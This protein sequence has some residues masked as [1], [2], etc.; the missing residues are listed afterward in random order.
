MEAMN[1]YCDQVLNQPRCSLQ[2]KLRVYDVKV[3]VLSNTGRVHEAINV[4][5]DALLGMGI[6]IPRNKLMRR[7]YLLKNISQYKKKADAW[8]VEDI[9]QL[10]VIDDPAKIQVMLL[11]DRLGT[12]A[13]IAGDMD[14]FSICS[15]KSVDHCLKDG[16]S[17]HS[18]ATPFLRL[19]VVFNALLSD[20]RGST[21]LGEKGVLL[22]EELKTR[23]GLSEVLVKNNLY[24]APWNTPFS[25]CLNP[26]LEAY[27]AGLAAGDIE[28]AMWVSILLSI[29]V[30]KM[31]Y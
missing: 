14:T 21:T 26:L 20:F 27:Q 23:N 17:P 19:G 15:M 8:D 6:K 10:P 5:Y 9:A 18:P 1:Q 24:I 11:C 30:K 2:D 28:N 12:A 4:C 16:F 13:Y 31:E 29:K 3:E 7:Y 25:N 22:Q